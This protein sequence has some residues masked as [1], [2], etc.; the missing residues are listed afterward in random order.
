MIPQDNSPLIIR[1]ARVIDPSS[2]RDDAKADIYVKD[3][4]FVEKLSASEQAR[5]PRETSML[6]RSLGG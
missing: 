2:G 3:G 1:G 5:A 6:L 4:L